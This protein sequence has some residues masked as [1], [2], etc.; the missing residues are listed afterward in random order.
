[1]RDIKSEIWQQ[2]IINETLIFLSSIFPWRNVHFVRSRMPVFCA[3]RYLALIVG[4]LKVNFDYYV[5]YNFKSE[6]F[7]WLKNVC[8][9]RLF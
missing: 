7:L 4:K 1:M 5:K 8:N 6:V 2:S 3:R 9:T